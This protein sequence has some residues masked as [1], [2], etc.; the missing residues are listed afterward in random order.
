MQCLLRCSKTSPVT[1]PNDR[2]GQHVKEGKP[3]Q[4]VILKSYV[5]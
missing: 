3:K 2:R 5:I 4:L 1:H